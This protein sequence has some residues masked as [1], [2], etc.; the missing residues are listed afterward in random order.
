MQ[1]SNWEMKDIVFYNHMY[2]SKGHILIKY[3]MPSIFTHLLNV[4][5]LLLC[6]L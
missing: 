1:K 5:T 3:S 2:L 4:S 6:L